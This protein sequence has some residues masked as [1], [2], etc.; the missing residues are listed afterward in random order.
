MSYFTNIT[1]E[2]LQYF[3]NLTV[4]NFT[5]KLTDVLTSNL[6]KKETIISGTLYKI[7]PLF[8]CKEKL[9]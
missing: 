5:I 9:K 2:E 8:Y 4:P 6:F 3:H 7:Y 1:N